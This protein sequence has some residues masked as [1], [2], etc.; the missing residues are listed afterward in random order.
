MQKFSPQGEALGRYFKYSM[1]PVDMVELEDGKLLAVT[2]FHV[3]SFWTFKG[4]G[5]LV[6]AKWHYGN[7]PS[8]DGGRPGRRRQLVPKL[9]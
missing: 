4:D 3:G 7:L 6:G 9:R 2:T 1:R 8:P 5:E